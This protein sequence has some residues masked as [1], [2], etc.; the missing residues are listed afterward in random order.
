MNLLYIGN[1]DDA[2]DFSQTLAK[3]E[4]TVLQNHHNKIKSNTLHLRNTKKGFHPQ[5]MQT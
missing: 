3:R 1:E 4:F 5:V 2:P